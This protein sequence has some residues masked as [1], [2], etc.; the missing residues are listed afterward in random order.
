MTVICAI[1][2]ATEVLEVRRNE[3][4]ESG[5]SL[6]WFGVHLYFGRI[7]VFEYSMEATHVAGTY[8]SILIFIFAAVFAL[9]ARVVDAASREMKYHNVIM[10]LR[11]MLHEPDFGNYGPTAAAARSKAAGG[12]PYCPYCPSDETRAAEGRPILREEIIIIIM[13]QGIVL[14][15]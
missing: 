3:E 6:S 10:L 2:P 12:S 15:I 14:I 11:Y 1:T 4:T 8:R 5:S 9:V 7:R 13:S